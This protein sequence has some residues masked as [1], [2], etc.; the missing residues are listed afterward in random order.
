MTDQT[1][2]SEQEQRQPVIWR[3]RVFAIVV[4][5]VGAAIAG[6][7]M[8]KDNDSEA[9]AGGKGMRT[10]LVAD[11]GEDAEPKETI[12]DKLNK[13]LPYVTE[14]GMALLLGMILGIG[15]RMA[16]NTIVLVFIVGVVATQFAIF[17]GWVSADSAGGFIGHLTDYVFNV[18]EGAE[19]TDILREKIPSASAGLLGFMMGLKRG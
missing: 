7:V 9:G 18:P 2:A 16:I 1:P 14:A 8:L 5:L 4:L 10:A 11:T 6:R 12:G 19:G 3:R 17:K 13:L 15:A